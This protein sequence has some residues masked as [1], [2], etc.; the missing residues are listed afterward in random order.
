[1][2][3]RIAWTTPFRCESPDWRKVHFKSIIVLLIACQC[4]LPL[5]RHS[6]PGPIPIFSLVD[7]WAERP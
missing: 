4:F 2:C 7:S 6:T 1:M 5:T 3:L